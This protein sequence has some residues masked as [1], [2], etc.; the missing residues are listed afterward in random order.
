M[1]R[2][3]G[4]ELLLLVGAIL[5]HGFLLGP[6]LLQRCGRLGPQLLALAHRLQ[7]GREFAATKTIQPTPLLPG[8]GELLGLALTGEIQQQ[9]PQLG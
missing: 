3:E 9:R 2:F 4:L 1:G 7:H 6:G 5:Q 8:A